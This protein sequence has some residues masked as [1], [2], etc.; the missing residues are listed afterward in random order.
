MRWRRS[1]VRGIATGLMMR[2]VIR[3]YQLLLAPVLPPSCRYLPSCSHYADEAIARHGP[4]RGS[5]L[6][7]CAGWPLP[8]LGRQRLRPGSRARRPP[9][10]RPTHA[11]TRIADHGTAQPPARD[12]AL[13]RRSCSGF[14]SCSRRLHPP[15]PHAQH[16]RRRHAGT[17]LDRARQRR[18]GGAC[19][20]ARRREPATASETAR[21][22]DRRP[23]AGQDRHAAPA[24]L[25]RADRRPDR[26]SD[27]RDLSRDGRP[28]EPGGRA[29]VADRHRGPYFAEFGWVRPAGCRE[30]SKVPGPG[31]RVD[32]LGRAADA[33]LT[34]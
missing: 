1:I 12:R 3:A 32:R 19:D 16:R 23:A 13:G 15:A 20:R 9:N 10:P 27:A 24:R 14:N 29:A 34:R 26:R 25:G 4:W 22:G 6:G 8:S 5:V 7:G 11:E 21:G 30:R 28:E 18:A 2:A 17:P 33:R 31:H